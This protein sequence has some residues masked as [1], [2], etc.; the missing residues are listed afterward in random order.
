M[1]NSGTQKKKSDLKI[2]KS[3]YVCIIYSNHLN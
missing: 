2:V 1:Q 3:A